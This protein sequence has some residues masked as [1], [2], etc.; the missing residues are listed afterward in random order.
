[1]NL[2]NIISKINLECDYSG[3]VTEGEKL[4]LNYEKNVSNL[5]YVCVADNGIDEPL[6]KTIQVLV[7]GMKSKSFIFI[8][9]Y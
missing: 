7:N 1:M 9:I 4:S 5:T 8:I 6:R 2:F 3:I